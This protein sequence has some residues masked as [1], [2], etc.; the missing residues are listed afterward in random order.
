MKMK[1]FVLGTIIV[2]Q[3][4]F[5]NIA[6]AK[7]KEFQK[8]TPK[9][10]EDHNFPASPTAKAL[11]LA[12]KKSGA[13]TRSS[14]S[15]ERNGVY[16]LDT[17]LVDGNGVLRYFTVKETIAVCT[18]QTSHFWLNT[19]YVSSDG[20]QAMLSILLTAKAMNKQITVY[21]TTAD[22]YCRAKLVGMS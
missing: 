22:N 9:G 11:K 18:L 19:S 5:S 15:V 10:P 6:F 16:T 12:P 17:I 8:A 13:A 20:L 21:Y 14:A 1:F 2:S 7:P 4:L 3:I